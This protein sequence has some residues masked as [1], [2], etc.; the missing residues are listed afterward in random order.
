MKNPNIN[1]KNRSDTKKYT[2]HY[3]CFFIKNTEY[4]QINRCFWF[5][6]FLLCQ[7]QKVKTIS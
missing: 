7:P 2:V 5:F 6:F 3:I 4:R 1:L